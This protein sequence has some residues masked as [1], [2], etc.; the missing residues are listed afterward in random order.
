MP[1]TSQQVHFAADATSALGPIVAAMP[2]TGVAVIADSN[3]ARLCWPMV[4]HLPELQGATLITFDAGEQHKTLDTCA[5]IW[6][7]MEAAGLTRSSIVVNLGGGVVTDM[8]GWC[9]AS[10]RRGIAFVNVPTTLLAA[11]DAAVGG[12]TGVNNGKFKNGIGAFAPAAHVLVSTQWL[13]TLP[14]EHLLSG[15]AEMVKHSLLES[16][17][18]FA[19]IVNHDP[20]TAPLAQLQPLLEHSVRVKQRIASQDP[21]E[22]GLRRALNLGHT[23]GHAL[24]SHALENGSPVPHGYAVA[25]GLVAEMVLSHLRLGFPSALLHTLARKV[26]ELYGAPALTCDHYPRLLNLM[27]HDKKSR[28]GEINCTLL[29]APG[30]ISLDNAIGAQ[31]MS[32]ALDIARDLLG[33]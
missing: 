32:S 3:T 25:W 13:A 20:L 4:Q 15:F 27:S 21:T 2:H 9:A 28:N 29:E 18:A 1:I 14:Q 22:Q 30:Q 8:G 19:G 16:G 26:R 7:Q 33:I 12:K 31:E 5:S 24:E 6:Q 11:V 10:Y 17:Q 23:V